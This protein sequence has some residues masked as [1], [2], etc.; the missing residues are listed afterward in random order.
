MGMAESDSSTISLLGYIF[1]V[2]LCEEV[3][4]ILPVFAYILVY[5]KKADPLKAVLIGIFSGLGFAAFEN[6]TYGIQ[7]NGNC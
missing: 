5:R 1:Q 2:G 7:G 3:I 6:M 4:K